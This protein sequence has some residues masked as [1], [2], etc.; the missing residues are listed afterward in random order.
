MKKI[1]SIFI[2]V[3]GIL[4][5]LLQ[6]QN[7]E[8]PIVV[9]IEYIPQS[10]SEFISLRDELAKT[11]QGGA[12]VFIL[13]MEAFAQKRPHG[14]QAL[15]VSVDKSRLTQ[16]STY[17]G[18][19]LGYDYRN[20]LTGNLRKQPYI[21]YTYFAGTMPE[22]G[23]QIG[24]PPWQIY[25]AKGNSTPEMQK[26]DMVK[27]YVK[28]SGA[29]KRAIVLKKNSRGIWKALHFSELYQGVMAPTKVEEDDL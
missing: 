14:K 9:D 12:A 26:K 5:S 19:S 1:I 20:Y 24:G 7:K 2:L 11:P 3:T 27:L 29:N 10:L 4:P 23:Y 18:Y 13:A 15:V 25:F 8:F 22:K 17:K 21:P 6:A 16:G 28:S